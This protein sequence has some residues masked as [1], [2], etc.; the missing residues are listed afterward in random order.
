MKRGFITKGI[1]GFTILAILASSFGVSQVFAEDSSTMAT[2]TEST[3]TSAAPQIK[4]T[5]T[6]EVSQQTETTE[7]EIPAQE[8][9]Q[10]P[11][12]QASKETEVQPEQPQTA[13]VDGVEVALEAP[14]KAGKNEADI[15]QAP[16]EELIEGSPRLFRAA[17]QTIPMYRLFNPH[18][19]EHFYT[20]DTGERDNLRRIGW[21]YE[22]VGWQ[23][24][25][26]GDPVYRLYNRYN[27]EHFYTLNA[28]ERDSITKQGWKYEGIGWYS[29]K[30]ANAIPVSRLYSKRVNWHHYT[31][32]ENEK[33]VITKQGWVYEG[34]GWYAVGSGQQN[35]E[36]YKLLGVKNYNQYALGAPSGCEGASLLQALQYKGKITNWSLTQFLNTIP[37]SPNGNPNSGFVGS[38]F[39]ENS[40]TY[41]AIYPAPLTTWGK[42]YGNAQNISGSSMNTLLNEVKNGH[43]VV[44]W[45]TINFQPIRWGNWNFGVAANNNHAVTLDGYNKGSNQVHVSDP[46]SGSYWMNRTT[47]ENIYNARKYAVV[48]R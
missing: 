3:Q 37:K 15:T 18:S 7:T 27:G 39:V 24:P 45:V 28:K 42:K 11:P 22:G 32:D 10:T 31:L 23:A 29:Y 19:G 25:T 16:K 6:N 12:V 48:V 5:E 20:R 1:C 43:P 36:D 17:V 30:G 4:N 26:S 46:I 14:E 13:I 2:S 8:S 41:S 40:W 33:K 9:Q 44:A 38:P 35:Q 47:F 34:V 21:N